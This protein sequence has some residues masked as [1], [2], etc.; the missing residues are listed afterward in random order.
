M[1]IQIPLLAYE[2]KTGKQLQ[3]VSPHMRDAYAY[4]REQGMNQFSEGHLAKDIN[5]NPTYTKVKDAAMI[6]ITL[7]EKM[8]R[9]P[10]FLWNV[11][12]FHR[13]GLKGAEL[14]TVAKEATDYAM[15]NYHP[16]ERPMIYQSLGAAGN[17]LG[18][19]STYKHN[20]MEQLYSTT[21]NAGKQPAAAATILASMYMFYGIANL[22]GG[23]VAD[24]VM[25]ELTGHDT[26]HYLDKVIQHKPLLDGYLSTTS[27]LDFASR[28]STRNMLPNDAT[29]G[30][31]GAHVSNLLNITSKAVTYAW[32]R[33]VQNRNEALLAA[34]PAGMRGAVE[35][36]VRKDENGFVLDKSGQTKFDEPRTDAEWALRTAGA[37]RPLREAL[38]DNS[39][40]SLDLGHKQNEDKIKK[41]VMA[42]K[43]AINLGDMNG[44]ESARQKFQ[45]L[46][47]N[48]EML[49]NAWFENN[50][51]QANI[52]AKQRHQGINPSGADSIRRYLQYDK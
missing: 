3:S 21:Q 52:S 28:L 33:N 11:D 15:G 49:S 31:L 44:F 19:L 7:G 41:T 18:P 35:N 50:A 23:D 1:N 4:A 16:D 9:L 17:L 25:Q 12:M 30:V 8:T 29:S 45:D 13:A 2:L 24:K 20:Y 46:G 42:M 48:A 40:R 6:P 51:T 27:G 10:V 34:S 39:L 14:H 38:E 37:P 47:G 22:P 32:E 26:R 36:Q 43:A 5:E